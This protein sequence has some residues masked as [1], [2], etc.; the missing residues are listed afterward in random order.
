METREIKEVAIRVSMDNHTLIKIGVTILLDNPTNNIQFLNSK[1]KETTS[2]NKLAI[3][4]ME[5]RDS[6]M[7]PGQSNQIDKMMWRWEAIVEIINNLKSAIYLSSLQPSPIL[8]K[9]MKN[10]TKKKKKNCLRR[11][12]RKKKRNWRSHC[13][14]W[15]IG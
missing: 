13:R 7:F 4:A 15:V 2:N 6:N 10:F 11:M 9:W 3:P 14:L 1:C 12:Y 5:I 8:H